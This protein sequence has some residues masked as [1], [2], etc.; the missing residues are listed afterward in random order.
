M[1]HKCRPPYTPGGYGHALEQLLEAKGF[2][3][4]HAG[5]DYSGGQCG[6]TRLG[7][8]CS[9]L[10]G[11]GYLNFAGTFDLIHFVRFLS[12]SHTL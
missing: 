11:P 9:N 3:V 2:A 4:Q 7:L 5:G 6:D 8:T 10:T 1:L 12:F